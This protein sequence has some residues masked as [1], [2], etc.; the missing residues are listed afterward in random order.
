VGYDVTFVDGLRDVIS[1]LEDLRSCGKLGRDAY[2]TFELAQEV[3][4]YGRTDWSKAVSSEC[5]TSIRYLLSNCVARANADFKPGFFIYRNVTSELSDGELLER[6]TQHCIS[7]LDIDEKRNDIASKLYEMSDSIAVKTLSES[8]WSAFKEKVKQISLTQGYDDA[9]ESRAARARVCK[10]HNIDS[11][12]PDRELP[13]YV[14]KD[15][16]DAGVSMN[17]D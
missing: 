16:E 17:Y 7:M 3:D 12:T 6:D 14:S 15:M 5:V 2:K 8:E 13:Y 11:A 1:D 4:E 9:A 10:R